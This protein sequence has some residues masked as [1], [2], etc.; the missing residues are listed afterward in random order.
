MSGF[1]GKYIRPAD[2]ADINDTLQ[3]MWIDANLDPNTKALVY[4]CAILSDKII[5][6]ENAVRE[7]GGDLTKADKWKQ[8]AFEYRRK[9]ETETKQEDM[10]GGAKKKK[11]VK[12]TS[13]KSSKKS[14]KTQK[15]GAKKS[16]KKSSKKT[17]KKSPKKT[18]KKTSK[19]SK[20]SKK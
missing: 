18:S 7:L 12:K 3:P 19:K 5:T 2:N 8:E 9:E 14:S 11:S 10:V 1:I 4:A 6:L 20:T 15:G 16:S 13:K 17:S